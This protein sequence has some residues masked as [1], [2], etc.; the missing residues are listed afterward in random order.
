MDVDP[1]ILLGVEASLGNLILGT[2]ER[3]P[4]YTHDQ[5]EGAVE[6]LPD[7]L[8]RLQI[9]K[10]RR[11]IFGFLD[12]LL[13]EEGPCRLP[14]LKFVTLRFTMRDQKDLRED[15]L[16]S[17]KKRAGEKGVTFEQI[18]VREIPSYSRNG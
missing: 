5:C 13:P 14:N 8:E 2:N 3:E 1:Y 16:R 17:W 12:S 10:C 15:L 11:S 9:S 18:D 6:A 4:R 7:S